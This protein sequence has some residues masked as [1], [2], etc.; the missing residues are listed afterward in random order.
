MPLSYILFYKAPFFPYPLKH[1][2]SAYFGDF[3]MKESQTRLILL[4]KRKEKGDN[5]TDMGE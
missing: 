2:L 4:S 5:K 1:S 3:F